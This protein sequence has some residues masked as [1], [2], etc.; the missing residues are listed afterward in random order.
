MTVLSCPPLAFGP[1]RWVRIVVALTALC[2]V[3][4]VG[5][6][7]AA[8][9]LPEVVLLTSNCDL[10]LG[11]CNERLPGGG[12][13]RF[14]IG[15][16]PIAAAAPLALH[17]RVSEGG[18]RDVSVDL[19]GAVMKMVPNRVPLAATGALTFAG[20]AALSLCV[21]GDM[22]WEARVEFVRDGT[23]YVRPFLFTSQTPGT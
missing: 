18:V 15:P 16:R 1:S 9:P 6:I 2:V 21:S 20:E 3:L 23:R 10:N 19:N 7:W 13:L 8:R 22:L 12:E 17:L 5:W 4:T 11:P 14:E